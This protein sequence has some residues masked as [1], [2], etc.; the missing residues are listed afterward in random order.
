MN[1]RA[2]DGK[3]YDIQKQNVVQESQPTPKQ[4]KPKDIIIYT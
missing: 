1:Y 4:A 2:V 3:S